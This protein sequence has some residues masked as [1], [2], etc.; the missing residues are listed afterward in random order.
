[1]EWQKIAESCRSL[2]FRQEAVLS[3]V[4]CATF[5]LK[6]E[7]VPGDE[8]DAHIEASVN[9]LL[10]A[11]GANGAWDASPAATDGL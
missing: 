7:P 3:G 6:L 2:G 4:L 9:L 11:C 8:R 10:K 1:M 5:V